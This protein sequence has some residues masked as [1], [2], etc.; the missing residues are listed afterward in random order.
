MCATVTASNV[1]VAV[2][3]GGLDTTTMVIEDFTSQQ[4]IGDHGDQGSHGDQIP[5]VE[6]GPDNHGEQDANNSDY[7]DN[8]ELSQ[9]CSTGVL[10]VTMAIRS[11]TSVF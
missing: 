5:Q 9:S 7:H 11:P 10:R 8:E 4:L 1:T 3:P 6:L 2:E